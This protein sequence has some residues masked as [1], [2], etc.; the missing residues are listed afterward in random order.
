MNGKPSVA[1][2]TPAKPHPLPP[3]PLPIKP[4]FNGVV[5]L[6][7]FAIGVFVGELLMQVYFNNH[8]VTIN[9]V[10]ERN[11]TK[12]M[13]EYVLNNV[14]IPCDC[15]SCPECVCNCVTQL[16]KKS[17]YSIYGCLGPN[18]WYQSNFSCSPGRNC[19]ILS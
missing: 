8:P 12:T 17:A 6:L 19:S 10:I 1:K 14:T 15:P 5:V 18:C 9:N 7:A 16:D 4:N 11:Y 13:V 2:P 3:P